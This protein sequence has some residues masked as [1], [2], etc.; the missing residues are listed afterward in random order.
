MDTVNKILSEESQN[1][2]NINDLINTILNEDNC[3]ITREDVDI[4]TSCLL[5]K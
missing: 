4:Y 3:I 2:Q 5:E 1:V